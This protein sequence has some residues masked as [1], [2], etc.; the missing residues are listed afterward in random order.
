MDSGFQ[1]GLL[2]RRLVNILLLGFRISLNFLKM[3]LLDIIL[4]LIL[5]CF[6]SFIDDIR[7]SI[8]LTPRVF[9]INLSEFD[10]LI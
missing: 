1:K 9:Q 7:H 2:F 4:V 10:Y 8:V 6:S 3:H 5:V